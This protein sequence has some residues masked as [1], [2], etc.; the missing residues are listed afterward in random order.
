MNLPEMIEQMKQH[1][2][3]SKAGM[4]LYHNRVVRAT[5]REGE[6]VTGLTIKVDHKRLAE[7][8]AQAKARTGIV[9]VL[10]HIEE[11]K[12]LAV[13][14]DVMFLAVAGDIRENVI[15]TLSHTLNRIK[16]EVTAK[17]QFFE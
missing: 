4:V 10:V 6:K 8:L 5:S 15:D 13:G 9:E 12:D 7:I 3:I 1:P 2:N 11:N 17:T 16:A 14:D